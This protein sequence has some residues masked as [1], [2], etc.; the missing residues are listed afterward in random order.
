MILQVPCHNYNDDPARSSGLANRSFENGCFQSLSIRWWKSN[1]LDGI[2]IMLSQLLF[3]HFIL[4]STSQLFK[5]VVDQSPL[6]E[7]KSR[8]G[9]Y[10]QVLS[11][12][13]QALKV[14]MYIKNVIFSINTNTL[15]LFP[16]LAE[17]FRVS[18]TICHVFLFFFNHSDPKRDSSNQNQIGKNV[19][20]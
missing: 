5:T 18:M 4:T 19:L 11:N 9:T 6:A 8:W 10:I 14:S 3:H 20:I 13:T 17:Y 15:E 7:A 12:P 1:I 2:L 16:I